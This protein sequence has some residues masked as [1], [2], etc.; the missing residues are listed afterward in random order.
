MIVERTN[1]TA[2][3]TLATPIR[4]AY[5]VSEYPGISHTFI[6]RE[7]RGLRA[8]NFDIRVASINTPDRSSCE[9]A[10]EERLEFATTFY[11]KRAGL[12]AFAMVHLRT[13][14]DR[15][16][17]YFKGL[18][19]AISLGGSDCGRIALAICYF[20]EAVMV[21]QW[22]KAGRMNHLHVHF[23]TA[24]STV[25]LIASRIFPIG[26]SFTVHGPDEFY[27]VTNYRMREK[28]AGAS[29]VVCI[30]YF[31]R[32][33]MMK[34]SPFSQWD[35]FEI[36]PLGVDSEVF[37]PDQ[38]ERL[39]EHFEVL[40][41]GRLV[42]AKGQQILVASVDLLVKRGRPIHLRMVGDGPDRKSLE[43]EVAR[44]GLCD[45]ITFEGSINQDDIR[46]LY[47]AADAFVLASFAEGIPVVL[48][49]AM[50]MEIACIST[51]IAGIPELIRNGIDGLLVEPSDEQALAAAIESLII[52]FAMRRRLA[53]AGRSRVIE[54]YN[55]N[56]NVAQLA[57]I[58]ANHLRVDA[59]T[60]RCAK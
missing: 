33:Q 51:A 13:L 42:S 28:I 43:S 17:S 32:S 6:L 31:A 24:A 4:I 53:A 1:G 11:V 5:L 38:S 55:L 29:F 40:S 21:G 50:A 23:A 60:V 14:L 41:V 8:L 57:H 37:R 39:G 12:R 19:F 15:P 3:D 20:V 49:E 18:F 7:V 34:L 46:E 48:M 2:P 59:R 56:H 27:D 58:F 30:G 45:R 47:S 44:R 52:D 54:K 16:I 26:F 10:R 9:M 22:M 25:G 35:K 36:A